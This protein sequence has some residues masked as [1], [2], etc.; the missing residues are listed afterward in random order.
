M[1]KE[2]RLQLAMGALADDVITTAE[3]LAALANHPKA[4][5]EET[6]LKGLEAIQAR[7]KA[8]R[9]AVAFMLAELRGDRAGDDRDVNT[10]QRILCGQCQG[11]APCP[12]KCDK[13]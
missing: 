6:Y 10:L 13:A 1:N 9:A 7:M 3:E 2:V 4:P 5:I 11:V 8:E 12:T